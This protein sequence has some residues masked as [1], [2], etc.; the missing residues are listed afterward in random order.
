MCLDT[1]ITNRPTEYS[2]FGYKTVFKSQY[3]SW[4]QTSNQFCRLDMDKWKDNNPAD[5]IDDFSKYLRANKSGSYRNGFHIWKTKHAAKRY[6]PCTKDG[7]IVKVQYEKATCIG[8]Q[9]R[10]KVI[11]AQ[12]IKP[13]AFIEDEK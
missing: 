10:C 8:T 1:I 3:N 6:L 11:V 2:G 7:K 5:H 13:V 12:R 9:L 4:M